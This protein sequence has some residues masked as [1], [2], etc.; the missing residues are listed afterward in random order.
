MP[1]HENEGEQTFPILIT[2]K[3]NRLIC[4]YSETRMHLIDENK[5]E[6]F[7]CYYNVQLIMRKSLIH[8]CLTQL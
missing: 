6:E 7:N 2:T 3:R 4:F 1:S 8:L 5:L